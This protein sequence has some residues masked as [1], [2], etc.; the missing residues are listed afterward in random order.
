MTR[1]L[2][3]MTIALTA[4][5]GTRPIDQPAPPPDLSEWTTNTQ[6]LKAAS[7]ADPAPDDV[8]GAPIEGTPAE[9]DPTEADSAAVTATEADPA[10]L[11]ATDGSAL[12]AEPT[13]PAT[14]GD[15]DPTQPAPP[16]QEGAP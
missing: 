10:A 11:T 5:G 4:C 7:A 13:P 16:A 8:D 15:G 12:P 1:V 14:G 3:A 2:V 6:A 9:A